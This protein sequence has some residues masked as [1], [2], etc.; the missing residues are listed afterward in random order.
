M[1]L[2][3]MDKMGNTNCNK[4]ANIQLKNIIE[5]YDL[6]DIWRLTNPEL[7]RFSWRRN[8][9]VIQSRLDYW[10]IGAELSFN[11]A[12][13]DIKPSIKTDHSMI[14][15]QLA[16]SAPTKKGHGL[17]KFN[18]NLLTDPDYIG[19]MKGIIAMERENFKTEEKHNLKWELIKMKFRNA[20]IS[21]SKI[22]SFIR[23]EYENE[24]NKKHI[25]LHKKLEISYSEELQAELTQIKGELENI[26]S[27]KTEGHRIRSKATYIEHNEKGSRYFINLEKRNAQMKNITRLK[28]EN[29]TEITD[30]V[31]ILNELSKFYKNLY[32]ASHYD[33]TYETDFF[34]DNIPK[35][36]L[37][38]K[39]TCEKDIS[40]Q[41]VQ[42]RLKK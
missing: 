4:Q 9:P 20:T 30:E 17:W 31:T 18:A 39:P 21:Y 38:E 13:C 32:R 34:T 11:I 5:E 41:N 7:K 25:D 28:L 24:L 26:N 19:Y 12:S 37:N 36:S 16:P 35:I 14:T 33:D 8:R 1:P 27:I 10:L 23:S 3:A 40:M 15:L 29:K 22:Q 2:E 42:K 6:L